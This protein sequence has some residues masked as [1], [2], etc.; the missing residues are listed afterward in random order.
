MR[1]VTRGYSQILGDV[2][3]FDTKSKLLIRT[4]TTVSGTGDV[5]SGRG[6]SGIAFAPN[7]G[8]LYG[9]NGAAG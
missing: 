1:D 7:S 9:V 4:F 3:V 5:G 8:G 6:L 2:S